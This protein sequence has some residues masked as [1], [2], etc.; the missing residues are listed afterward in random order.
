MS[1]MFQKIVQQQLADS[2]KK[3]ER[4]DTMSNIEDFKVFQLLYLTK[5]IS[6]ISEWLKTSDKDHLFRKAYRVTGET[7]FKKLVSKIV[8]KEDRE[9]VFARVV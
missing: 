7:E 9:A 8:R 4:R 1:M 6:P 3:K 2:Q 5:Y